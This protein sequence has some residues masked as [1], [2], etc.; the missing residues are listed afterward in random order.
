MNIYNNKDNKM[1]IF[2]TEINPNKYLI[3]SKKLY[4]KEK[5]KNEKIHETFNKNIGNIT[6]KLLNK[7]INSD[8]TLEKYLQNL[9]RAIILDQNNKDNIIV[10]TSIVIRNNYEIYFLMDGYKEEYRNIYTSDVLKW[11]IIKKYFK[12]GYK[13]FNLGEI[14]KDY[15]N[16]ESKYYGQYK[17]KIGFGGNVIEYTPNLLYIINKPL[18]SAYINLNKLKPKKK[19]C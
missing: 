4:E 7:K 14:H 9:N 12:D 11:A 3:N 18:Y 17:Y 10:G 13:T 19:S 2:F 8:N 15:F 16:K 6:E 5:A 1:E